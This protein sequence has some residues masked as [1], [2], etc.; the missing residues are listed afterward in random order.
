VNALAQRRPSRGRRF[1]A[2]EDHD[3]CASISDRPKVAGFLGRTRRRICSFAA[4][5]G[6]EALMRARKRGHAEDLPLKRAG[7]LDALRCGGAARAAAAVGSP[8]RPVG[9]RNAAAPVRCARLS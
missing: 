9:E 3:S 7:P 5:H 6:D 2:I 8:I 4:A 1:D